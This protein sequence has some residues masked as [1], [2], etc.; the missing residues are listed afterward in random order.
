MGMLPASR[1]EQEVVGW[2][3]RT[4]LKASGSAAL[5]LPSFM[6]ERASAQPKKGGHMRWGVSSGSTSNSPELALW[7][8]FSQYVGLSA[9]NEY[10]TEIAAD[11]TLVP[12]VAESWETP[13]RGSTWIFKL[14]KDVVFT[15][16]KTL[17]ADDVVASW[18]Y[19]KGKD[20]KSTFKAFAELADSTAVDARTVKFV[21][22]VP[23]VDLPYMA[24]YHMA[25]IMPA[26]DGK[27]I[28]T[29]SEIGAGPYILE[30]F[31][32]GVRVLLRKNE[33]HWNDQVGHFESIELR[34]LVDV[35]ARTNALL[36]GAVDAIDSV[37]L[38][39]A[40]LLNSNPAIRLLN[41]PSRGH[42][43]FPMRA[44]TAPFNDNNVRMALK[45][46]LDREALKK[47][48]ASEY[49]IVANDQPL[50]RDYRYFDASLEQRAYDPEKAKWYLKQAGLENLAVDLHV[51]DN[52][53]GGGNAV[54]G[55][56]IYKETAAA[57]GIS[58]NVVREAHD[59]YWS[60]VWRK[61]PFCSGRAS[62]FSTEDQQF[63]LIYS[64]GVPYNDAFWSNEKADKLIA[65]ARSEFDDDKRK[66]LYAELQRL[67]RDEGGQIIPYFYNYLEAV[68][69]K[70]GTPE[71]IGGNLSFDGYRAP[72]RWWFK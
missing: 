2:S 19:H 55:A 35:N 52:S 16:G 51:S 24:A 43:T 15:N 18:N 60:N 4:F 11:G 31:E 65:E 40:G 68:S 28:T 23:T 1:S 5:M 49:G 26:K 3:R 29:T 62:G 41:T 42:V 54:D 64:S 69:D 7:L 21:S 58:I 17:D 63:S 48:V 70:I 34:S 39:T 57:A 45:L 36:T 20:S 10:L 72:E 25:A 14:R 61:A 47:R 30:N 50:S 37:Q 9:V 59:G 38:K 46:A 71:R 53:W 32:P 66:V 6:S 12:R 33:N 67:V 22:Q 8:S 56:V 13:D 27:L 44:D